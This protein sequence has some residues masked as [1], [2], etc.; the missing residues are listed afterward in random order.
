MKVL[1]GANA[2]RDDAAHTVVT[3]SGRFG[4]AALIDGHLI[5]RHCVA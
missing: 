3:L 4:I 5:K 1:T 2:E